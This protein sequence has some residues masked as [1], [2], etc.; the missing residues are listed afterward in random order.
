MKNKIYLITSILILSLN[1]SCLHNHPD[2]EGHHGHGHGHSNTHDSHFG[3]GHESGHHSEDKEH[4]KEGEIHLTKEQVETVEI[5]FG[6]FLE[7]KINDYVA[8]TG[9]LGLPPNAYSSVNAKS[10]GFIKDCKKYVEGTFIKK[11]V[12]MAFLENPEFIEHQ[13]EYLETAAELVYLKQE[14]ARQQSLVDDNAGALKNLQ[15]LQSDVNLETTTAKSIAKQLD[16]LG[17]D[18]TNLS[19]EN[20]VNRIS[21]VAPMSGYITSINM[22]DGMYVT[23]QIELMEVVNEQHLHLELAVFE[24]DISAI[25]VEQKITYTVPALGLTQYEGD[26]HILGREFDTSNKTVRIHGHLEK[27]RPRFIKD[28]FVEAKIWLNDQT[29]K[30]L[31]EKAIVKIGA[32]SYVYVG[33]EDGS[34]FKFQSIR[35]LPGS[36]DK[37]FT[38][39]KLIDPIPEDMKMVTKG[40][41][42]VYAQSM[43]G[44]LEHSH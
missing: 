17:I 39:V 34:K 25:K 14:L 1:I 18:V 41:Y 10:E 15:K 44:E 24:K 31:P 40:A 9:T 20:L 16:Y 8:T 37:G 19:T 21:I 27:K 6:D 35:V 23:P 3:H 38:S 11:G 32:F 28:L 36:T 13:R 33:K 22:H 7:V 30:A 4:H 26:V 42:Y 5:G 2:G 12:V 43:V 29:V